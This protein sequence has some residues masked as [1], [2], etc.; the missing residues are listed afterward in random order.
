MDTETLAKLEEVKKRDKN[1]YALVP[2]RL[3]VE[4]EDRNF[5]FKLIEQLC[6]QIVITDEKYLKE[7]DE[8]IERHRHD[9]NIQADEITRL[10]NENKALGNINNQAFADGQ[11]SLALSPTA[12]NNVDIIKNRNQKKSAKILPKR[13]VE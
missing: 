13:E 7:N 1:H 11:N 3:R 2:F 9:V 5:L 10:R 4:Y 6:K 8:M 12:Q